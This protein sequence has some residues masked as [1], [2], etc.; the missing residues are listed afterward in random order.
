MT[1]LEELRH[2]IIHAFIFEMGIP[3][4]LIVTSKSLQGF[5]PR[6]K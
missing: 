6:K 2:E 1:F 4:G 5:E 3:T